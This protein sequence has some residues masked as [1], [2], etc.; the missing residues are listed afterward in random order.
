MSRNTVAVR[1]S[2]RERTSL[3]FGFFSNSIESVD[4]SSEPKGKRGLDRRGRGGCAT[5]G[6]LGC[7]Q[8][9]SLG[10]TGDRSWWEWWGS[11]RRADGLFA[12]GQRFGTD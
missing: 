10:I 1:R 9:R 8:R 6:E 12:V 3:T 5:P 4:G 7:E 11:G 2:K